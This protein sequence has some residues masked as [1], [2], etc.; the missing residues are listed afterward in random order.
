MS[1]LSLFAALMCVMLLVAAVYVRADE[2][3]DVDSEGEDAQLGGGQQDAQQG[4]QPAQ[5]PPTPQARLLVQKL[6]DS[7]PQMPW[8]FALDVPINVTLT[9]VN[10]GDYPA[11][12]VVLEDSWSGHFEVSGSGVNK[13][14][15]IQPGQ[16][17]NVS[18]FVTP[19]KVGE[20]ESSP[21]R[22]TYRNREDGSAP[23]ATGYSSSGTNLNIINAELFA[24]YTN[25]HV[26]EWSVFWALFALFLLAPAAD[27]YQL[28]SSFVK[29]GRRKA[30]QE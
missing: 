17:V 29:G 9:L 13:W 16:Q 5:A 27:W 7:H 25:T 18:Y 14:D 1:R 12:D 11:Q 8:N 15:E 28:S 23:Q 21:A 20:F 6:L 10:L 30:A 3:I 26:L 19:V 2:E 4:G 24:K 22:V